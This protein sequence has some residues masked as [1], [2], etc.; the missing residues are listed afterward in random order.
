MQSGVLQHEPDL[1][2]ADPASLAVTECIRV[3]AVKDD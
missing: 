3:C 2:G 1:V